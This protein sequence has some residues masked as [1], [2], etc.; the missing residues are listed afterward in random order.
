MNV[1]TKSIKQP[2]ITP[3]Q[4]RLIDRAAKK[5]VKKYGKTL[6]LLANE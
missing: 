5:I 1:V 4:K 2:D 6:K 3:E